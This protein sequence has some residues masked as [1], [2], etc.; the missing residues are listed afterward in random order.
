MK[1]LFGILLGIV[2]LIT[3]VF[4]AIYLKLKK[5]SQAN[6]AQLN[7]TYELHVGDLTFGDLNGNGS[8]DPYEDP[9]QPIETRVDDLLSQMTLAEKVGLMFQ[10][11]ID[12]GKNGDV[13]EMP[14]FF[15]PLSTSEMVVN[16]HMNHFNIVR[17]FA[18]EVIAMWVNNIQKMAEQTRLGIPITISTDPR[19]AVGNNPGAGIWMEAFSHGQSGSGFEEN[20]VQKRHSYL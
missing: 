12:M 3:A 9:R 5:D 15:S 2:G 6:L 18:P 19:H 11:M 20:V 14:N 7:E 10:P 8:L 16:R 1:K 4:T 17:S 13:A